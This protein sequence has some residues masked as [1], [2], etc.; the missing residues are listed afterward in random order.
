[1]E[2]LKPAR[3]MRPAK[4]LSA[5]TDSDAQ[6]TP[7][8]TPGTMIATP[9]GE[10]AVEDLNIGDKI[11]TRDDGIKRITWIGSRFFS[12][13]DLST[14]PHLHPIL[15]RAGSLGGNLPEQDLWLSPNHRVLVDSDR[16]AL[17]FEERE[18]LAAAKHLINNRGVYG[19]NTVGV[20]YLHFMFDKHCTVL[21]NG[22]WTESFQPADKTLKALG[23]AQR[24]ELFEIFPDILSQSRQDAFRPARRVLNAEEARRL[25]EYQG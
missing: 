16:T 3:L 21:S 22:V 1:M 4:S 2:P 14:M 18:V 7:C 24:Q 19:V 23:N 9:S 6:E 13:R 8:F 20:T 15:I 11:V 25:F 17:Y 5:P 10:V 12:G